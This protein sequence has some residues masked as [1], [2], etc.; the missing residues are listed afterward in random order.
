MTDIETGM[1]LASE[2]ASDAAAVYAVIVR[3]SRGTWGHEYNYLAHAS[4]VDW[5]RLNG[6]LL[7][8]TAAG[9]IARDGVPGHGV[10]YRRV[11]QSSAEKS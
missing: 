7:W 3:E 5:G 4:G 1:K 2:L 10:Y 8:L 6:V 9:L 11:P